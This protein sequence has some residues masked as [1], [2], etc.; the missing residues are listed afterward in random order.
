M[1]VRRQRLE[2]R[3][4]YFRKG[5]TLFPKVPSSTAIRGVNLMGRFIA[6][7]GGDLTGLTWSPHIDEVRKIL[8]KERECRILS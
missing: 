5:W 8:P 2:E 1:V 6:L 7:S 4:D 3:R